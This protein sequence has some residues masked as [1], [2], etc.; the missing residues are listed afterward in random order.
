M[1]KHSVSECEKQLK[2]VTAELCK[3]DIPTTLAVARQKDAGLFLT[4]THNR[5][6]LL[7]DFRVQIEFDEGLSSTPKVT[8]VGTDRKFRQAVIRVQEGARSVVR[9]VTL[10]TK[11]EDDSDRRRRREHAIDKF[12]IAMPPNT[13]FTAKFAN[14][15]MDDTV[16]YAVTGEAPATDLHFIVGF[17]ESHM[18][19]SLLPGKVAGVAEAH[20][21]LIPKELRGRTDYLRQGEFF[22]VPVT[23]AEI[24]RIS[25]SRYAAVEEAIPKGDNN[26]DHMATSRVDVACNGKTWHHYVTGLVANDRHSLFLNGWYRVVQNTELPNPSDS[27]TWD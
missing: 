10:N 5:R 26:S 27:Q 17:D 6:K 19:I 21:V 25:R 3:A 9:Q 15:S 18:F 23:D 24:R 16:T 22:F 12:P 13:K 20:Q 14:R 7:L 2:Q 8:L 1:T 11:Y 4:L